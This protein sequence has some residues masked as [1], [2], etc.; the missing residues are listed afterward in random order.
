M[1]AHLMSCLFLSLSDVIIW[2][3]SSLG[4]EASPFILLSLL[5]PGAGAGGGGAGQVEQKKSGCLA[6]AVTYQLG[7]LANNLSLRALG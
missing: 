4:S 6:P 5:Q 3:V 2:M 7:A 1:L